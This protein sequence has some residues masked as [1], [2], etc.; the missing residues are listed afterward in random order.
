MKVRRR[1]RE[2]VF[3]NSDNEKCRKD[4]GKSIGIPERMRWFFHR[5]KWG[6]IH[7]RQKKEKCKHY[8]LSH[9]SIGSFPWLSRYIFVFENGFDPKNPLWAENGDGCGDVIIWCFELSISDFFEIAKFPQRIK[10]IPSLFS[11]RIRIVASVKFSHP[12]PW[13]DA[14]LPCSTVNT[15]FRR[16]IPCSAQSVRSVSVLVIQRSLS[17]SLNIFRRLGWG[18]LPLGTEK[19]NPIAAQIGF[20]HSEWNEESAWYAVWYGSCP[21]MT[22][23]TLSNGVISKARK[24]FFPSG[25]HFFCEYSLF[26]KLVRSSQYGFSNSEARTACQDE[27]IRTDIKTC[28]I[29]KSVILLI[30]LLSYSLR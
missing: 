27:W 3:D 16:S 11:E 1:Y 14:G 30:T 17:N 6:Y 9:Q 4:G 8:F 15:A 5:K 21:R 7:C 2:K 13:C 28:K 18:L 20:C 25:K 22:T 10:T 19:D 26:I 24:I 12:F 23:F 29:M